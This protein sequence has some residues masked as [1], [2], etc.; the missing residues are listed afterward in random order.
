MSFGDAAFLTAYTQF[1]DGERNELFTEAR[2]ALPAGQQN[3]VDDVLRA[4]FTKTNRQ[5][6]RTGLLSYL[7]TIERPSNMKIQVFFRRFKAL[8]AWALMLSGNAP[9]LTDD[10]KKSA[11][12]NAM[13]S[14]FVTMFDS[15]HTLETTAYDA[16]VN[17]FVQ[18][19]QN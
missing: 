10:E 2:N 19:K 15:S 12:Y 3:V 14:K 4:F 6:H 11:F 9:G 17:R 18:Y 1:L 7:R 13:P 8:N 5:A 16:V